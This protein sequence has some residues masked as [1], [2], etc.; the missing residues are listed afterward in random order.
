[1]G[2]VREVEIYPKS[3]QILGRFLPLVQIYP[4]SGK[5]EIFEVLFHEQLGHVWD[6]FFDAFVETYESLDR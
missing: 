2:F 4:K 5:Q 6:N 1:M 3:T